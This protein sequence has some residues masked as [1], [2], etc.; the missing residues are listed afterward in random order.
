MALPIKVKENKK[1]ITFIIVNNNK[2][3]GYNYTEN[4]NYIVVMF[5]DKLSR[6]SKARK[7]K[8]PSFLLTKG[9]TL[10]KRKSIILFALN[11]WKLGLTHRI[12][13]ILPFVEVM[14]FSMRCYSSLISFI[15]QY[16]HN[17][18]CS[19]ILGVQYLPYS[20][21]N[22][23]LLALIVATVHWWFV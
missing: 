14:Q 2:N 20:I 12:K 1:Q 23:W 21:I 5:E 4:A 22:L 19:G 6:F 18:R 13:E 7:I 15:E 3:N 8:W 16:W 10:L 17:L 9:S 11:E